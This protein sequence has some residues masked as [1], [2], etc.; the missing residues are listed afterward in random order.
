M[1][2]IFGGISVG[3][4]CKLE[5]SYRVVPL[6]SLLSEDRAS[7]VSIRTVVDIVFPEVFSFPVQQRFMFHVA[8]GDT[9]LPA[10]MATDESEEW[11]VIQGGGAGDLLNYEGMCNE[12]APK[13][14]K[15]KVIKIVMVI[16]PDT[17]QDDPVDPSATPELHDGG[18][19]VVKP[20][21]A[22]VA[23]LGST[24]PAE[25]VAELVCDGRAPPI[26]WRRDEFPA[27]GPVIRKTVWAPSW[28]LRPPNVE[29]E[30]WLSQSKKIQ[31]SM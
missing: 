6:A 3:L 12:Y 16:H 15:M 25:V 10:P 9:T 2:V 21:V 1:P 30:L 31:S 23:E 13:F 28:S 18:Y 4:G 14:R 27:G 19:A 8:Y 29:P 22:D 11:A 26:G 24:P 7:R 5:Y 17:R 20:D